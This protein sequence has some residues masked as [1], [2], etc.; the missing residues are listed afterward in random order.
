MGALITSS[1]GVP[2]SQGDLEAR[3]QHRSKDGERSAKREARFH[4]DILEPLRPRAPHPAL[5]RLF[6]T[7]TIAVIVVTC[8]FHNPYPPDK[9][10]CALVSSR[11]LGCCVIDSLSR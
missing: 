3:Q 1:I 7:M 10:A 6:W 2:E 11:V 5:A 4:E 8:E 9:Y